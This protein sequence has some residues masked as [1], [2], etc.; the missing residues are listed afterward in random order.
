MNDRATRSPSWVMADGTASISFS[1]LLAA[2]INGAPSLAGAWGAGWLYGLSNKEDGVIIVASLLLFP[3]TFI[4]YGV[5]RMIFA[6]KDAVERKARERDRK[7]MERG[8]Q[9]ERE[10][11]KRELARRGIELP[12]EAMQVIDCETDT[13]S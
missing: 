2:L 12:P 10:R 8:E 1:M 13:R 7:V 6:A 4:I 5:A 9:A 3:S 11:I